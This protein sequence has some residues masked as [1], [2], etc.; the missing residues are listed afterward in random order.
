VKLSVMQE[1]LARGLQ[2][3]SR[4]VSTRSTL[5]VLNNV[6]LRTEDGGLKLTATNLEIGMTYWVPGPV[7]DGHRRRSAGQ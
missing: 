5:P 4:A 1:N 7:A 6:L 2:V 3:V